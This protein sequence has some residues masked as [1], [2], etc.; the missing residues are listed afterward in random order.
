M[1]NVD[2]NSLNLES[3][4][5]AGMYFGGAVVLTIYFIVTKCIYSK[6]E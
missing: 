2:W 1:L 6:E 5:I 4:F 3:M